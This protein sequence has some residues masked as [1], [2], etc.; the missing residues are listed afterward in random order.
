M[1]QVFLHPYAGVLSAWDGFGSVCSERA[2]E[3]TL[4]EVVSSLGQLL[5]QLEADGRRIDNTEQRKRG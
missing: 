5:V 1:K 2:V 3:A 4:S